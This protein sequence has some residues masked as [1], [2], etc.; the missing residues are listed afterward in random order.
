ME[1]CEW[2]GVNGEALLPHLVH[3]DHVEHGD[4]GVLVGVG[5][6][7]AWGVRMVVA[8]GEALYHEWMGVA[9]MQCCG[10]GDM[11]VDKC[12]HEVVLR[13]PGASPPR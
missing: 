1:R 13:A 9:R 4:E 11:C 7:C 10:A 6:R 2:R 3:Y 8:H 5:G 12:M